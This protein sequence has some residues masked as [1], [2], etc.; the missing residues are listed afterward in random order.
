M[1]DL[2]PPRTP[3]RGL[4]VAQRVRICVRND[5]GGSADAHSK[6]CERICG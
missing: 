6:K 5:L 2:Y 4:L 3:M 1:F